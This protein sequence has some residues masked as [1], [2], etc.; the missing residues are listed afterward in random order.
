MS[1]TDVSP[2]RALS[3]AQTIHGD[4]FQTVPM[5]TPGCGAALGVLGV[6]LITIAEMSLFILLACM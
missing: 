6:A 5:E 3:A 4:D 1:K 2:A